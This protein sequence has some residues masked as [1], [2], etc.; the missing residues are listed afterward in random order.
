[1]IRAEMLSVAT[2]CN[3]IYINRGVHTARVK[4]GVRVTF[5]VYS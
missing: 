3:Y 4:I 1:M 2:E 5:R